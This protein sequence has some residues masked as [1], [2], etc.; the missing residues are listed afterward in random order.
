M[1]N[2]VASFIPD[3]PPE[4][5]ELFHALYDIKDPLLLLPYLKV[6]KE[7]MPHLKEFL[8]RHTFKSHSK[9]PTIWRLRDNQ[10]RTYLAVNDVLARPQGMKRKDAIDKYAKEYDLTPA[11]LTSAVNRNII[12]SSWRENCWIAIMFK[13]LK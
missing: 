1:T 3:I 12:H 4:Y 5:A 2:D 8:R 9:K 6:P 11:G 7:V 10:L 13:F